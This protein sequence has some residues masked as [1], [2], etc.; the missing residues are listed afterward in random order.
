MITA[1]INQEPCEL[2]T[3]MHGSELEAR[4]G[5]IPVDYNHLKKH[6]SIATTAILVV[7]DRE[8]L[9]VINQ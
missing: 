3:L 5:D 1:H 6:P 9:A 8:Y 2:E 4:S 7:E